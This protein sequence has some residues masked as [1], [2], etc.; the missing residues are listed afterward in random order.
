MV[1]C[2]LSPKAVVTTILVK[3][4]SVTSVNVSW[5]NVTVPGIVSYIVYYRPTNTIERRNERSVTVP[6]SEDSVV[7]EDLIANVEYQFQVATIAQLG[8]TLFTGQRS[9]QTSIKIPLP[10]TADT[11]NYT[12]YYRATVNSGS[13]K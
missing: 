11:G 1:F 4:L 6:S 10:T 5:E 3:P 9:H 2:V 13:R 12:S 7:I 8:G